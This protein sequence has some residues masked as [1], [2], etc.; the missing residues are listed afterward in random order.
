M[1]N[2]EV[3]FMKKTIAVLMTC[4]FILSSLC[5]ATAE[6]VVSYTYD[7][8]ITEIKDSDTPESAPMEIVSDDVI[9]Q[10]APEILP[11]TGGIPI[12]AFYGLGIVF[13]LA[14]IVI[15]RRKAPKAEF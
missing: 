7:E 12:E 2:K 13:I 11:Q 8:E 15:S 9:P 4:I 5:I 6:T 10:A 3:M 14:A 1:V